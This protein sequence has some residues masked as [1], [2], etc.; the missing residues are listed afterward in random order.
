MGHVSPHFVEVSLPSTIADAIMVENAKKED[1]ICIG[2]KAFV[3]LYNGDPSHNLSDL[4]Y[5]QLSEKIMKGPN[6]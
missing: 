1:I 3:E 2:E 5:K 6:M 4:R